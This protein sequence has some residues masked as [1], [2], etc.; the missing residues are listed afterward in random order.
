[1]T[2]Q[3]NEVEDFLELVINCHLLAAA[4]HFFS[5]ATTSDEPHSNGFPSN[6]SE[7][8]QHHRKKMFFERLG[9]I[10]DEYV[11]P[12]EFSDE[13]RQPTSNLVLSS[14]INP[15]VTQISAEHQYTAIQT[16]QP[17]HRSLPTAVTSA[18]PRSQASQT[19]KKAAPDGVFNYASAVLNDGLLLLE[20]KD[21]IRE[22]DGERIL[23]CWK[24]MLLYFKYANHFNYQKEAFLLL[25][26]VNAAASPKIA[27]QLKW[28]RTVN[29]RGGLGHNIPIDLHMEHLNRNVKDYVAN[30]GANVAEDTIVQSG[31]SLGGIMA[32]CSQFDHDN[33]VRPQSQSHT[34]SKVAT[35]QKEIIKELTE[36]SRVFDYVPGRSHNT[37]R[38][39][40]P[41]V[42][43]NIDKKNLIKWIETQK[44]ELL[45]E[46]VFAKAYGH[47]I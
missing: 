38:K 23:R 12:R 21:A 44:K 37:F 22:G 33:G 17:H 32:V 43:P 3:V 19:V 46:Q 40:K 31:K 14:A 27:S 25:A 47:K 9:R 10:I 36:N 1:M 5:M 4:M 34:R 45:K 30:L 8:E 20:Y 42:V 15:H 6:I 26:S 39:I 16:R 24:L 29:T 28:S 13:T 11:V 35:D 41:N 2:K 18:A 7:I